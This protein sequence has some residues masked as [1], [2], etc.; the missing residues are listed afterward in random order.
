LNGVVVPTAQ[1]LYLTLNDSQLEGLFHHKVRRLD[2]QVRRRGWSSVVD[3]EGVFLAVV[4]LVV[5]AFIFVLLVLGQANSTLAVEEGNI[6]EVPCLAA[7][8]KLSNSEREPVVGVEA[9][10]QIIL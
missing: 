7:R 6:V 1:L 3:E 5:V 2:L 10:R 9:E 8:V 4:L